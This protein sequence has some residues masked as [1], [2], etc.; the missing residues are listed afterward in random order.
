MTITVVDITLIIIIAAPLGKGRSLY[1]LDGKCA[2]MHEAESIMLIITPDLPL[3]KD[4]IRNVC[5]VLLLGKVNG[6]K[7][8]K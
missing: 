4:P 5:N 2:V 8:F 7:C 6:L 1:H 3:G